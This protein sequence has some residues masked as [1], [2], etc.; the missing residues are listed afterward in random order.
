MNTTQQATSFQEKRPPVAISFS[1]SDHLKCTHKSSIQDTR[2][3][4][5]AMLN[6]LDDKHSN[7]CEKDADIII[8]KSLWS[9]ILSEKKKLVKTTVC[10]LLSKLES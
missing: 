2:W 7:K 1:V 10:C 3:L 8:C 6:Y 4:V 5:R 9:S